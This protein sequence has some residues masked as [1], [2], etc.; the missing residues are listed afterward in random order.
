MKKTVNNNKKTEYYQSNNETLQEITDII[1]I[2]R[3]ITICGH[4]KT[5]FTCSK[6]YNTKGRKKQ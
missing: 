3:F 1:A 5:K 6:I 4:G 2:A